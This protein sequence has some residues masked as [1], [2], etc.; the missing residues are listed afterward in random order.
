[1]NELIEFK[2]IVSNSPERIKQYYV[3]NNIPIPNYPLFQRYLEKEQPVAKESY[4]ITAVE[5]TPKQ[6]K[7]NFK[8]EKT[9]LES[10]AA[11]AKPL[12][13]I[14][15]VNDNT[16]IEEINSKPISSDMKNYLITM[17]KRESSL[18]PSAENQFGYYGL[19]QFGKSALKDTGYTKEDF[20]L[21]DNQHDAMI[22]FTNLNEKRLGTIINTFTGK[23][24][25]GIKITK[26][27]IL[28][29][30]HLLGPSTVKDWF[31]GTKNTEIAKNGF[32]DGNGTKLEEYLGMFNK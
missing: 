12:T 28:A 13:N 16:I 29:A 1:M 2:P 6:N 8:T 22:K 9:K 30:A 27:G 20:N 15:L 14:N 11:K 21:S 4:E 24:K 32:V 31:L 19:Y 7:P 23:T 5:D 18:N 25:N 26:N 10:L 3:D 17:A